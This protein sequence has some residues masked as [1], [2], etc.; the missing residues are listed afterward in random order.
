MASPDRQPDPTVADSLVTA[1]QRFDF[2]QAVRLLLRLYGTPAADETGARLLRE[3]VRFT[4][5]AGLDFP[6]SDVAKVEPPAAPG[7]PAHME[8]NL[9]G[10]AGGLGPLPLSWT[11][12][13][14]ERVGRRDTAQRDFLDLFTQRLAE[15]LYQIRAHHRPGLTDR[16]PAESPVAQYLFALL[17]LGTEGL[18]GRLGVSD[19]ALLPYTGL[20]ARQPR[21]MA[22][23]EVLLSTYFQVPV[24]GEALCGRWYPLA[25]EQTTRLGRT[26][27]NR[28]LGQETVL[29]TRVWLQDAALIL[30]L[31]PLTLPQL[32]DV[33]P[34]GRG[35]QPLCALTRFYVGPELVY[36][37]H[38]TLPATEIPAARLSASQGARLGWT[39][40]L[41]T[42][43]AGEGE[44]IVRLRPA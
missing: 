24:R 38:L 9:L 11:E 33:L 20:L 31:G 29:G 5:R 17:G 15:L 32:L 3:A 30:W 39:S 26:G 12:A 25:A 21:S 2:F 13:L 1:A 35:F 40:W 37:V 42:R 28:S 14:L 8:V 36:T 10:L 7:E 4:S 34:T 18:R 44:T 16:A 27:Q 19:R 23:L 22:G 41:Q 43:N 6:A